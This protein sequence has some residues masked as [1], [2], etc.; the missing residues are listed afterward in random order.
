MVL[1]VVGLIAFSTLGAKTTLDA[2]AAQAGVAKVLTES[3]GA[4]EVG[5]VSCPD[6]QEV[7]A[8]RSFEC[9]LTVD[10]EHRSVSLTFTDD[11]GTY[12]VSRP[13]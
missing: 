8:G 7:R 11:Q 1:A 5:E 4:T 9:T 13:N 3:Y 6:D 12:E 10:G 2:E